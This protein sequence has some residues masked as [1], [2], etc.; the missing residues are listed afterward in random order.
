[1]SLVL[2]VTNE[3]TDNLSISPGVRSVT[4]SNIN[5]RSLLL[6]DAAIYAIITPVIREA[7]RLANAQ[8]SIR[9]PYSVTVS[10]EAPFS[11]ARVMSFIY[12]G[13]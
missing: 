6:R 5:R 3:A 7:I 10:S 2:L 12:P 9:Y 4:L 11:I 8:I 13:I 1:M